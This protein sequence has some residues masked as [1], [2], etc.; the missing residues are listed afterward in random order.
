MEKVKLFEIDNEKEISGI[1]DHLDHNKDGSFN[2]NKRKALDLLL[3]NAK[4]G[5]NKK[6]DYMYDSIIYPVIKNTFPHL[7]ANDIIGVQPLK[8]NEYG[9]IG[10]IHTLRVRY[11]DEVIV[12][13]TVEEINKK[14]DKSGLPLIH[15]AEASDKKI[16]AVGVKLQQAS[17][18]SPYQIQHV[19]SPYQILEASNK[20]NR[21]S[22][23][24]LKEVV[25]CSTKKY[26]DKW[27]SKTFTDNEKMFEEM[28]AALSQALIYEI[29]NEHLT[30]LREIAGTPT[31]T[32]IYDMETATG[33]IYSDGIHIDISNPT[34][35]GDVHALLAILINRQANLIAARTRRGAGNWCVVSPTA[36]TILQSATTSAFART[37]EDISNQKGTAFVGTLNNHM[38][39]YVDQYACDAVPVLVGYKGN[40]IDAPAFYIPYQM[41]AIDDEN[42]TLP[43]YSFNRT[44]SFLALTNSANSLGNAPDY[45]GTVGINVDTLTFI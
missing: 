32:S 26:S 4:S 18:S 39:V 42:T 45:L 34:F 10:Q 44:D 12:E 33:T 38:G 25:E 22:I 6:Y 31:P 37:C 8:Y 15:D 20:G 43:I 1:I 28:L 7:I 13:G 3:E 24:I 16:A 2:P 21:L 36:L 35:V 23:Q 11:A 29:D 40:D 27:N 9:G 30:R 41:F 14:L 17:P 19:L 5:M